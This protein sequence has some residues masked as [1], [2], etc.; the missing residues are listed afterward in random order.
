[1]IG[2]GGQMSSDLLAGV[3]S[4][5]NSRRSRRRGDPKIVCRHLRHTCISVVHGHMKGIRDVVSL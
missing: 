3:L 2:K 5:Q 4:E 1:M